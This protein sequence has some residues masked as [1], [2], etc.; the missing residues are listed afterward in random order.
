MV[1]CDCRAVKAANPKATARFHHANPLRVSYN[2]RTRIPV[3][4]I[5]ERGESFSLR[6]EVFSAGAGA[7]GRA[8]E[9]LED[10]MLGHRRY[11]RLLLLGAVGAVFLPM[12][13]Q[14]SAR[15]GNSMR[16]FAPAGSEEQ[17]NWEEKMRAI[18]QP[19][20]LRQYMAAM[21]SEPHHLGSP[22]DKANAEWILDRFK[23]WGLEAS[24]EE[25]RVLFPMPRERHLELLGPGK[26]VAKLEEPP[27]LEDQSSTAANVLP[28]YNAFSPDGD[29]TAQLVYVNYGMPEDY[30]TLRKLGVDVRGK[31]VL[32]RYG[33]GWRGLKPKL[34]YEKG[35]VGCLIYSD[36]KDDG[37]YRG[38]TYP[39]GPYR[40]EHGV[41]RGSV[42]DM[43]IYPGDP[44]TPDL[45]A[46]PDAKR[47][48]L[49]EAVT[50]AKVPVLPISHGDAL[51]LLRNLRGAIAP[52]PWR[53]AL[54]VTYMIGPG[55]AQVRLRISCH[56]DLH[57][58]YNVIARIEGSTF[59]DEWIVQGN[60]HDAPGL[61]T[62]YGAK[63]VPYVR[64]ALE[65]KQWEEA[66]KGVGIVSQRL[67]AL[68]GQLDSAA[69]LLR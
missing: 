2:A 18:P 43:P 22:K 10:K 24:I 39:E 9:P 32:T 12:G 41:Q 63:T 11:R 51:P 44:L 49:K 55:P 13:P 57:P 21:V 47:L 61:Y 4:M 31:I 6:K 50:I 65:Q 62:G 29:V 16:G 42:V 64:E 53:G 45:A 40:P 3:S 14:G 52:E 7:G 17:R 27:V 69:K 33:G 67:L 68:S 60:H 34:A 37:Y 15:S 25:Y 56:W 36:P 28:T 5:P 54:P 8:G 66:A 58:V 35:A 46:V 38:L 23:S 26:Y 20:F 48:P 59:P 1:I 19:D 30:E